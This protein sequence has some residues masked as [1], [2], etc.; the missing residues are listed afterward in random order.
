MAGRS[1]LGEDC[2]SLLSR[3]LPLAT[4]HFSAFPSTGNIRQSMLTP[5]RNSYRITNA[6]IIDPSVNRESVDDILVLDGV[7]APLNADAPADIPVLDASGLTIAPGFVDIHVHFRDPGNDI[8]ETMESGSLAAAAGGFTTVVTMPNTS[9]AMDSAE[10]IADTVR[11]ARDIGRVTVLPCGCLTEGRLGKKIAPLADM[12]RAGAVAF[13]DDGSTVPDRELLKD[14]MHEAK[15]LGLPVMDH[16]QDPALVGEGV[17]YACEAATRFNLPVIPTLSEVSIVERDIILAEETGCTV[18]I[19]H[20]SC[21]ESVELIRSAQKDGMPVTAEASPHHIAL[22]SGSITDDN[23]N[24]KMNPPLGNERDRDTIIEAVADNTIT[25]LA[26]D[27]APHLESKKQTGFRTAPFG[28]V[29]LETAIGAT[30]TSLVKAGH[31]SVTEWIRRWTEGPASIL[32]IASPSLE[33][34]SPANMTIMDLQ[35]IWTVGSK[36][37]LSKSR[38]TPFE[39]QSFTCRPTHTFLSGRMT[40]GPSIG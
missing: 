4:R 40:Y 34:G 35:S 11:R 31:M 7:I 19:Q 18:H 29:G 2:L 32:G 25:A 23:A 21:A 20:I 6:M 24:F 8:A 3:H 9:P 10:L 30:Y 17:I 36:D 5:M 26:T 14:A 1:L 33:I 13:S 39:G 37:F 12:A 22:T 16:A 27:H 38:N 28:V 15:E